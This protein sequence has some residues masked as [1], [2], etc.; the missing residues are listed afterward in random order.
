MRKQCP[1]PWRRADGGG[2]GRG[3]GGRWINEGGGGGGLMGAVATKPPIE[4]G[5]WGWGAA[6]TGELW[7]ASPRYRG[8][9]GGP[10]AGGGST[11]QWGRHHSHGRPAGGV[12]GVAH[13]EIGTRKNRRRAEISAQ[14]MKEQ[15][16]QPPCAT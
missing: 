2:G 9:G 7:R 1:S 11:G 3:R 8:G 5:F 16:D 13:G 10:V 6:A 14:K 12:R 15:G 4:L